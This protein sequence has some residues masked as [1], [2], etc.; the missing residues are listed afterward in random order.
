MSSQP[1]PRGATV[2]VAALL[3]GGAFVIGTTYSG[4]QANAAAATTLPT[5]TATLPGAGGGASGTGITVSGTAQVSGTPDTLDLN[6]SVTTKASTVA[7][8]LEQANT[9]TSKVQSALRGR[10]VAAKDLQTSDLQIQPDY[11]YPSDGTAVADGYTVT[12]SLTVT[13]RNLSRAGDTIAAAT[14]AGGNAIR[15]NGV[16]LDL[17]DSG[18]LVSAARDKAV[19]DARAKA[20][21]YAKAVG[22]PLGPVTSLSEAV[23]TP[24]RYDYAMPAASDAKSVPI[25]PG[26]QS[27]GVTVTITY[28]FGQ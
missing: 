18:R 6:L 16:S 8:A 7:K 22:R 24:G 4:R 23:Q 14:S 1:I 3:L 9:A 25:S 21:Q 13:L 17:S 15:I 20:E 27:V 19:A 2:V 10:G 11:R 26:S 28:A 12:E 5:S